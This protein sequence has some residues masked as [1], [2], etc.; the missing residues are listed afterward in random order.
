[1]INA[2]RK[3]GINL[4]ITSERRGRFSNKEEWQL[5]LILLYTSQGGINFNIINFLL[6][7]NNC[8]IMND[9]NWKV[10]EGQQV[11]QGT[12]KTVL[13][14]NKLNY[15]LGCIILSYGKSCL[16]LTVQILGH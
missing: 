10:P 4:T 2:L 8:P 7:G 11:L 1:L 9:Q 16:Y 15:L 6:K 14:E 12:D 5:L 13:R 3:I